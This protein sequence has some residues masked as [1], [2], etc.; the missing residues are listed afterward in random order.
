MRKAMCAVAVFAGVAS[1]LIVIQTVH[2]Q[3]KNCGNMPC[4]AILNS[5]ESCGTYGIPPSKHLVNHYSRPATVTIRVTVHD[6]RG[7]S[8]SDQLHDIGPQGNQYIGCAGNAAN[9][10][11]YGYTIVNVVWH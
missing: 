8:T 11:T 9:G 4:V 1:I 7:T 10:Q 6:I 5:N 3:N 2:A